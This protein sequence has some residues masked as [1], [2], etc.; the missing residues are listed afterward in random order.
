M[1]KSWFTKRRSSAWLLVLASALMVQGC[2]SVNLPSITES[3]TN[4]SL[5]G[6]V[7]WHDLITDDPEASARFYGELFGWEFEQVGRDYGLGSDINYTLIRHRGRLI[8]GM[9]NENE[10]QRSEDIS[11]WVIL[12]SVA[13]INAAVVK[14]Q[15]SGGIVYTPPTELADRGW[16]AVVADPQGA[17]FTLVQT[18]DGDPGDRKPKIGD[19]LWD[20]VWTD[21]VPA[22]TEFYGSLGN[23]EKETTV[24]D[25]DFTYKMLGTHKRPRIGL[26]KNPVAEL[27]PVWVS[28]IRVEDPDPILARVEE[29]GGTILLDTRER[30]AG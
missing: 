14:V 21:D 10:L 8:G 9:V 24:L 22:A 17:L 23:F 26:V 6:K 4:L 30:A 13:D 25:D 18:R 7:V 11:Q 28:Y 15:A 5:S 12:M 16:L 19:F 29:L 1:F 2:T 27:D 3:P 20:E